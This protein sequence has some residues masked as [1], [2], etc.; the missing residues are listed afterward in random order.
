[1]RVVLLL[2][3]TKEVWSYYVDSVAANTLT[4]GI[5]RR[6]EEEEEEEEEKRVGWEI[7]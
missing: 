3:K 2:F 1:M 4:S 7:L 6:E 5:E